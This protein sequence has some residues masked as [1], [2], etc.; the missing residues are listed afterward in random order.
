MRSVTTVWTGLTALSQMG[1]SEPI[2]CCTISAAGSFSTA[3]G[4]CLLLAFPAGLL[5]FV[6][7]LKEYRFASSFIEA[8]AAS[9]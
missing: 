6:L 4:G 1:G 8:S 7:L 2:W 3:S 5:S 9:S